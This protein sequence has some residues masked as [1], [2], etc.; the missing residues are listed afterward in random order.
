MAALI[1][2]KDINKK[3]SDIPSFRTYKKY[4]QLPECYLQNLDIWALLFTIISLTRQKIIIYPCICCTVLGYNQRRSN[5]LRK[6][7]AKYVNDM[8]NMVE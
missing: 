1:I 8:T 6:G 5:R 3:V 2:R 7:I 4:I